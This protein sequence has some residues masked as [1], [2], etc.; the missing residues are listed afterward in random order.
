MADHF[1][2][3]V[4]PRDTYQILRVCSLCHCLRH[5]PVF[6]EPKQVFSLIKTIHGKILMYCLFTS[7]YM[8]YEGSLHVL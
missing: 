5:C 1:V 6:I 8:I 3:H 2:P 4:A 7:Q